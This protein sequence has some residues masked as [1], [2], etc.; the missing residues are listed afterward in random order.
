MSPERKFGVL[1]LKEAGTNTQ[2]P[3][4]H[5]HYNSCLEQTIQKLTSGP[6]GY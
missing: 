1:L 3:G 2:E 6:N 5:S 4:K